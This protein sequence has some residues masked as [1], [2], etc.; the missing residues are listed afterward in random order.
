[1]LKII[2]YCCAIFSYLYA[3]ESQSKQLI[4]RIQSFGVDKNSFH[5]NKKSTVI[6]KPSFAIKDNRIILQKSYGACFSILN[7]LK[8]PQRHF[9]QDKTPIE[10]KQSY[11]KLN[12]LKLE[13]KENTPDLF[14]L[15]IDNENLSE[16][17]PKILPRCAYISYNSPTNNATTLFPIFD[18][19]IGIKVIDTHKKW[20]FFIE[21]NETYLNANSYTINII[22]EII[23]SNGGYF[24]G[25]WLFGYSN[26]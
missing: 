19:P 8:K 23:S 4:S 26:I 20:L 11:P 22:F 14:I 5:E 21:E 13:S 7:H 18:E 24:K 12:P 16:Q 6:Y 17:K 3:L 1:M 9:W 25:S 10:Y 2:I 15:T